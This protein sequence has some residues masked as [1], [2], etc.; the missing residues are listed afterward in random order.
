MRL[1]IVLAEMLHKAGL[2]Q[3][4]RRSAAGAAENQRTSRALQPVTQHGERVQTRA[5]DL[6]RRRIT[7]GAY[8]GRIA[9]SSSSRS[10]VPNM[11]GPRMR[12]TVTV[13]E[14]TR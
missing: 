1:D 4:L 12:S 13:A 9:V 5:V 10:V 2:P 14:I 8:R 6:R 11:N 7:M 3:E